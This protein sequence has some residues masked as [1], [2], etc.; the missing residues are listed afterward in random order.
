MKE[1]IE[2]R[3]QLIAEISEVLDEDGSLIGRAIDVERTSVEYVDAQDDQWVLAGI[4]LSVDFVDR[5][6]HRCA[7]DR[8]MVDVEILPVG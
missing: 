3:S 8:S 4:E 2:Q 5:A 1:S 7:I 6:Q